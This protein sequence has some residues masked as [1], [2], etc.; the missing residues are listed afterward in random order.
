MIHAKIIQNLE[1]TDCLRLRRSN[2]SRRRFTVIYLMKPIFFLAFM[3]ANVA[4]VPDGEQ[5][6]T[7]NCSACHMLDE[8]VVGPSLVEIRSIYNGKPDEFV[9]WSVAPEKK[10]DG[11]IEMPSM[12]HLGDDGL[13]A[14]YAH[15]MQVSKGVKE[16]VQ[17]EGDPYAV[18]LGDEIYPKVQRIFMPDAGPAAIAIALDAETSVCWDAGDSRFR[19][20]W[21][22]GFIDGYPYW[23]GNGSSIAK[24]VG[25]TQY[26]EDASPFQALGDRKFLGYKM[27]SGLPVLRYT[28]GNLKI[29]EKVLPTEK[30]Q[31]FRRVF[32]VT[33]TPANQLI[34]D[35]PSD[36]KVTY[37]SD[38]GTWREH[39]LVLDPAETTEFTV[40]ITLK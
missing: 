27:D 29:S 39:T 31:S 17:V 24:L 23:K 26:K 30:G 34:L 37:S 32:T 18:S 2:P 13:R 21:T 7:M 5:L 33:P 20:A 40:T 3:V 14:V 4:A 25:E 35:F 28:A 38:Q 6:F 8:M 12:V 22:G 11:V 19:Y 9:Q 10:R 16:K 15:V 1:L 36:Q